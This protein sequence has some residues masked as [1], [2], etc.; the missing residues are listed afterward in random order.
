MLKLC[1][2]TWLD[3]LPSQMVLFHSPSEL[4][5][6]NFQPGKLAGKRGDCT[7]REENLQLSSSLHKCGWTAA[8]VSVLHGAAGRVLTR[9]VGC[10]PNALVISC[11]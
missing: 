1:D 10:K 7:H 4:L 8:G 5:C 2:M 9:C 3:A 11:K 6:Y